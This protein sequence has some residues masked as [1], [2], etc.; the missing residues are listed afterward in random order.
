[1]TQT[2]MICYSCGAPATVEVNG[3]AYCK[4]DAT[5]ARQRTEREDRRELLAGKHIGVCNCVKRHNAP[6]PHHDSG[7]PRHTPF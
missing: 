2:K 5:F 3:V 7:C 4:R 1:M 6:G